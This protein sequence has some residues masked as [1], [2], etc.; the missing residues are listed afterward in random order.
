MKKILLT[1]IFLFSVGVVVMAQEKRT[2]KPASTTAEKKL[3]AHNQAAFDEK[4]IARKKAKA[5]AEKQSA[6]QPEQTIQRSTEAVE[7]KA[8]H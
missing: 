5:A 8:T 7:T 6:P 4:Q 3:K 1:S 2:P